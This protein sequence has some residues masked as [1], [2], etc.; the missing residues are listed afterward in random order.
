MSPLSVSILGIHTDLSIDVG[1][2]G[3]HGTG[4]VE[5]TGLGSKNGGCWPCQRGGRW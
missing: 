4:E 5:I 1:H 3:T 2:T